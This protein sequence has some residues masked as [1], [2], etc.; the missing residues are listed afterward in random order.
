M[1]SGA[2]LYI[3][4]SLHFG[5]ECNSHTGKAPVSLHYLCPSRRGS[6]RTL[7]ALER[8]QLITSHTHMHTHTHTL[9]LSPS[10]SPSLS[11][12]RSFFLSVFFLSFFLSL[13]LSL[14]LS[15]LLPSFSVSLLL[16]LSLRLLHCLS[17][18]SH[19]HSF[20]HSF[21]ILFMHIRSSYFQ[22]HTPS[23]DVENTEWCLRIKDGDSYS[24]VKE[25]TLD[26]HPENIGHNGILL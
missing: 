18:F 8:E 11:L 20:I 25:Q 9:S 5:R 16:F 21:I 2:F 23:Y 7:I 17:F 14:S 6:W 10:L 19:F 22:V 4:I 1:A 26:K 15:F 12:S 13:F 24:V 3:A